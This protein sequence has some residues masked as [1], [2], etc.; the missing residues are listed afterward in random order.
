MAEDK[1]GIS[2]EPTFSEQQERLRQDFL[3]GKIG[4]DELASKTNALANES[5][6]SWEEKKK[7]RGK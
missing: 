5:F 7:K 2:K 4:E 3:E 6:N 1:E